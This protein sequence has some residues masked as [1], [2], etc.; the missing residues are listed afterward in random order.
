MIGAGLV[1]GL[2]TGLVVAT[3]R[4]AIE[5]IGEYLPIFF[6]F[7]KNHLAFLP[8]AILAAL[9]L[10]FLNGWLIKSEPGIK[11]S[12]IP[13]VEGQLKGQLHYRWFSVL[14][15][16]FIGGILSVG[17]GL[18]LGR[19]GPSIQLGASVGQG[20]AERFRQSI[21]NEKI[22]ISAGSAAGLAAA[23]NA[24]I[25][26]LLFVLEEVHHNFSPLVWLTSLAAA[27]M[28]N[29]VSLYFFGLTPVLY[30]DGIESL[31]LA[32]YGSLL[33]LGIFLGLLA[34]VYQQTLLHL[35]QMYKRIKLPAQFYSLVPFLLLIPVGIFFPYFLGG[36]NQI[37][38]QLSQ[39]PFSFWGLIG[40]FVLRFVF[41]M[42]SYGSGLPGGI[43]LPI[44][45]LGAILGA[46]FGLAWCRATGLDE[47]FIR[48]F[49]IFSM[50]GYFAAIGKA[51]LTALILVTEMV[52]SFAHLM[53]LG[54]VCLV[55]YMTV[56]LFSGRP[57]YE[58][59]LE[60]MV[61]PD[62]GHFKGEKT[63]IEFPVTVDSP[64]AGAMVRDFAW[65]KELLL[66]S[67]RRGE[68]E[69]LTR[70][71]TVMRAGDS[72]FILTDSGLSEK[73][74]HAISQLENKNQT[75]T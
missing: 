51:P 45:T 30:M 58:A 17:S 54:I 29:F 27:L 10:T 56:D 36:G 62:F 12:G 69:I 39:M 55:A 43:F 31:P 41:S 74:K 50:A 22:L 20:I 8:I 73:M 38:H 70:G 46:I 63:V 19:E 60:K 66:T 1:V 28:S 49:I 3:F 32:H 21:V 57:I 47:M 71:D 44:L 48:N 7:L 75:P 35:P 14:P 42:I 16:K 34:L 23:F 72:L 24:P 13:Q 11:G 15:K 6:Q 40:L 65:P 67:I 59:L 61:A 4:L 2:F 5:K 9:L 53:P 37:I 26:G 18:F 25:A 33:V 64:L 52:G 68:T